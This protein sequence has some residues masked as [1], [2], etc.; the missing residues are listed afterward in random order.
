MFFPEAALIACFR[1]V[2]PLLGGC[3]LHAGY[4][5]RPRRGR[6]V[7]KRDHRGLVFAAAARRSCEQPR[8]S[9]ARS[10]ELP[11][12]HPASP[13]LTLAFLFLSLAP[14]ANSKFV[15]VERPKP[16]ARANWACDQP[17][18]FRAY[19]NLSCEMTILRLSRAASR[20]LDRLPI[21]KKREI[22][23]IGPDVTEPSDGTDHSL[24]GSWTRLQTRAAMMWTR[25]L[26]LQ[27]PGLPKHVANCGGP[28]RRLNRSSSRVRLITYLPCLSKFD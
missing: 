3:K 28:G 23:G 11:D 21:Q 8:S 22:N 24:G 18:I 14:L 27:G 6:P 13:T 19:L 7:S 17:R 10:L 12:G 16:G 20:G 2:L 1:A 15:M 9:R 4:F 5:Q 25:R 26:T